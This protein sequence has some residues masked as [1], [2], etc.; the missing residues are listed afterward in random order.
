[1]SLDSFI[2]NRTS[3]LLGL[4]GPQTLDSYRLETQTRLGANQTL[5]LTG[6]E[7][8]HDELRN[9]RKCTVNTP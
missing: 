5:S 3:Y 7:P 8:N 2:E 6:Y 4:S 9:K 1:M